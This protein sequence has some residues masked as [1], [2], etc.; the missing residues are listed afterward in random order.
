LHEN[1][2]K[3]TPIRQATAKDPLRELDRDLELIVTKWASLPPEIKTAI[4]ALASLPH[5]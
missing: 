1:D 5:A 2:L 3:R 4:V